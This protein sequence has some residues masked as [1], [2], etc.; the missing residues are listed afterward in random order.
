MSD[1][2]M[3]GHS[4]ALYYALVRAKE[5]LEKQ[6]ELGRRCDEWFRRNSPPKPSKE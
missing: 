5:A 1:R 3:S 2:H 6:G 4:M